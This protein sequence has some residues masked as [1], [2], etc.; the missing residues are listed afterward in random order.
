MFDLTFSCVYMH[1]LQTHRPP[2]SNTAACTSNHK[3]E[4][5]FLD[6]DSTDAI[7]PSQRSEAKDLLLLFNLP[8]AAL[9]TNAR[10]Q[11]IEKP[12]PR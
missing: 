4:G 11:L 1:A 5:L 2:F 7:I 3:L 12:S 6:C 10:H 9:I 8:T